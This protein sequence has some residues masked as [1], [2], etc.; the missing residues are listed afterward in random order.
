MNLTWE[1]QLNKMN[2]KNKMSFDEIIETIKN[3]KEE[4]K[5]K[6][7]VIKNNWNNNF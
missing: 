5:N 3:K 4:L 2:N 7:K 6:Y 1:I